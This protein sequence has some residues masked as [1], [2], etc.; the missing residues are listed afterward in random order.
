MIYYLFIVMMKR[1]IRINRFRT[2]CHNLSLYVTTAH[3][4]TDFNKCLMYVWYELCT[5][6][7]SDW[8]GKWVAHQTCPKS[9]QSTV[10]SLFERIRARGHGLASSPLPGITAVSHLLLVNYPIDC[11]Y[12]EVGTGIKFER[13]KGSMNKLSY[14]LFAFE[15]PPFTNKISLVGARLFC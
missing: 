9:I 7:M 6:M 15:N 11:S 12:L 14:W 5:G 8:S 2:S 13:P 10:I 4:K 3:T 1:C